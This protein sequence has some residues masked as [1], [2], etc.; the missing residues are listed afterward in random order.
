MIQYADFGHYSTPEWCPNVQ[1]YIKY[2]T[3]HPSFG[4]PSET[5]SLLFLR[6]SLVFNTIPQNNK[7]LPPQLKRRCKLKGLHFLFISPTPTYCQI[8]LHTKKM[9]RSSG[10]RPSTI[11]L[12]DLLF[13]SCYNL[14]V[15]TVSSFYTI[16]HTTIPR[17]YSLLDAVLRVK[18][19][20]NQK[21]HLFRFFYTITVS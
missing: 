8:K 14:S 5:I 17:T 12:S 2:K 11:G 18:I 13:H 9:I 3:Q 15:V 6:N 10:L 19:A 4:Q 20:L 21:E 7:I 1:L 16:I